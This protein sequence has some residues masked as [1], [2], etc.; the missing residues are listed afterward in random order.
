MLVIEIVVLLILAAVG[1]VLYRMGG[2]SG[3]NTKFRDFGIPTVGI[4]LLFLFGSLIHSTLWNTLSLILTFGLMFAAQTTYFKKKGTAPKWWNWALV[5]LVNGLALLPWAIN[6][7]QWLAFGIRTGLL[8]ILITLWC[9]LNDNAVWE[10]IGRG[11][12]IIITLGLFLKWRK[13]GEKTDKS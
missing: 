3:Y 6:T 11:V 10:E 13:N 1:G 7:G 4:L 5:G 12:L 8:V 9:E 2:A